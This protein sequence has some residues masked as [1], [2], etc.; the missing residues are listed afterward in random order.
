MQNMDWYQNLIKP[1]GTP[2]DIAFRIIWPILYVM[3]GASLFFAYKSSVGRQRIFLCVLFIL[4]LILNFSWSPIFFG[5][6]NPQ[7]AMLVLVCLW[8]A[9][10]L[11]TQLSF[12]V[13]KIAGWLLVPYLLW[14][15]Y[16][17]YLNYGIIRLN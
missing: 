13:S 4:Q 5:A 6:K 2:P 11:L 15:T 16:A 1:W 8:M 7:G 3:M 12:K 10:I 14:V 9:I 17:G